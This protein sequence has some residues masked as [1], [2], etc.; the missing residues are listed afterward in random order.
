MGLGLLL[1]RVAALL[2]GA[3][4]LV[5]SVAGVSADEGDGEAPAEAALQPTQVVAEIPEEYGALFRLEWG[6]GSL[7]HL[8]GRLATMGCMVNTIWLY[9]NN[10][11]NVY[12]QY[13]LS[14]DNP[15]IQQ[16]LQQYKQLIPATTL[17]ANCYNICEFGGGQCLTF[18]ELREREGNFKE[19]I[20][21]GTFGLLNFEI[22]ETLPCTREFHS[23]IQEHILP[24]LPIR[25]D[26]C[27]VR[28]N[29]VNNNSNSTGGTGGITWYKS[30]NA[31][32]FFVFIDSSALWYKDL[33][34]YKDL[35]LNTEIHEL[36]HMNQNWQQVQG[37]T[38]EQGFNE[39]GHIWFK[40][41]TQGK[42]FIEMTGFIDLGYWQ[43]DLSQNNIYRDIYSR[44]PIELS[45]ELCAMYL[46]DKIGA[47]QRNKHERWVAG[48][49]A[50]NGHFIFGSIPD[51][52]INTYLTPEIREWL[53]TYMILPK[54]GD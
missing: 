15:V 3:G 49:R 38:T 48:T 36:C 30:V 33:T 32:P 40:N 2:V 14:Q 25:P 45:A 24:L 5:A 28:K 42:E 21:N 51:F 54:I 43:W 46:L 47:T 8:K 44:N 27:I 29:E 1:R 7:L 20:F 13:N 19:Y 16:F 31:P 26:A 41:S 9:D 52:N 53:E 12:N 10:K 18:D 35:A 6:G 4:L 34:E 50:F 22:D 23:T 39:D 11:W 17:W 37:L